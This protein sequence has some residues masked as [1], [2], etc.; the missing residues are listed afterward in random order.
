LARSEKRGKFM[1]LNTT[2]KAAAIVASSL[3][4]AGLTSCGK[5]S[6]PAASN[7]PTQ[8]ELDSLKGEAIKQAAR[9]ASKYELYL[10]YKIMQATGMELALGGEQQ[11]VAALAAVSGAFERSAITA[12]TDVPRMIP[13]AF[14]GNG[15]DAG[16]MGVGYGLFGGLVSTGMLST[17]SNETVTDLASKGPLKYDHPDRS[18]ELGVSQAGV[19][20][21]LDQKVDEHGLTGRVKTKI[22][23]DACPDADGRLSV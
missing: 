17:L 12:Q 2:R 8:A 6:E 21:A 13:A 14:D 10:H 7:L 3:L 22:H 15:F 20:T 19:D 5:S 16:V 11:T 4:L 18:G 1:G 23:L 9:E